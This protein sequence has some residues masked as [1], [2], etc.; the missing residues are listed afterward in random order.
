MGRDEAEKFWEF[1]ETM[2]E[3][4]QLHYMNSRFGELAFDISR[5]WED[6]NTEYEDLKKLLKNM[7]WTH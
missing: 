6:Y 2:P 4:V 5:D 1:F 7:I 3:Q